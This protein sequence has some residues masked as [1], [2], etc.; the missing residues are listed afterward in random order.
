MTS[1]IA[2]Q[3]NGSAALSAMAY[4]HGVPDDALVL[5]LLLLLL[6]LTQQLGCV[7]GGSVSFLQQKPT[8]LE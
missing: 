5:V 2:E 1:P 8:P 7:A 4:A 3:Q 6:L